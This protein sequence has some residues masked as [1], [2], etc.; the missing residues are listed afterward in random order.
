MKYF[1]L[2]TRHNSLE[3]DVMIGPMP[4]LRRQGG[5][6]RQ[7]L[8]DLCDWQTWV[9]LNWYERQKTDPYIVN[10]FIQPPTPDS[11]SRVRYTSRDIGKIETFTLQIYSGNVYQFFYKKQPCFAEDMTKTF[12]CAFSAHSSNCRSHSKREY[13]V[14]QG[15]LGIL[16]RRK[17]LHYF[18]ANLCRT[19]H[20]R[21]YQ[22]R[23]DFVE[24]MT[25]NILVC[26][27]FGLQ[28]VCNM[29]RYCLFNLHFISQYNLLNL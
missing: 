3:K 1:G 24:D 12:W 13:N 9:C 2:V 26:I 14:L 16:F 28:C 11:R 29:I 23:P 6:R 21:F 15:N 27:V 18:A 5:Q 20:A 10:R 25:K 22:N 8:D 19:I 7:W 17:I 4:G